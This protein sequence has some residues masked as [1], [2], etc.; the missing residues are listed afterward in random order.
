[1]GT[2]RERMETDLQLRNYRP[3]TQELYL[4]CATQLAKHYWR[5]PSELGADEVRRYLV[6]LGRVR[7][8]SPSTLKVYT[9]ALKFLYEV[10]LDRPEVVAS[11]GWPRVASKL[12]EVLSG[13]EVE[14]LIAAIGSLKYRALASTLYGAGLRV[15]EGCR[16]EIGDL[17]SQRMVIHVRDGKGGRDRYSML[18]SRL[19]EQLREYWR[20]ERPPRPLV[21]PGSR[22]GRAVS[23]EAVRKA[24]RRAAVDCGITKKVSPHILRHSFAT[25]LHDTGVDIRTIQVLLGHRSIRT[26]Q[27]YSQ[28][29]RRAIARTTSPLDL[30]GTPKGKILG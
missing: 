7:G 16:L 29:S 19:L 10:T 25:H 13:A 5:S 20:A 27:L 9:A 26:T 12:P 6:H 1:M 15:S 22:P 2:L 3:A 8:R 18:S 28:V 23:P 4:H 17:D 24:L 21:F 14:K 11:I 30:L